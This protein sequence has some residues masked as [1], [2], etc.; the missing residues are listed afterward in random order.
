MGPLGIFQEGGWTM[1]IVLLCTLATTPLAIAAAITAFASK[2]K[3]MVLGLAGAALL[4]SLSTA[5]VGVSGYL[6]WMQ[7]VDEAIAFAS[8]AEVVDV[9]PPRRRPPDRPLE[10]RPPPRRDDPRRRQRA[11][12]ARLRMGSSAVAPETSRAGDVE[13]RS[14]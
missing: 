1:W 8:D 10:R 14:R 7:Q 5:C 12:S 13:T 3:G 4:F 6:Y 11:L 9:R 2:R